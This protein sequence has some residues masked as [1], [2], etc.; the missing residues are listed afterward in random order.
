MENFIFCVMNVVLVYFLL[1]F[2]FRR[3]VSDYSIFIVDFEYINAK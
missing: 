2:N 1:N 3:F